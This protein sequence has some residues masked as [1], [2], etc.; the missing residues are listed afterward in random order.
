MV[1]IWLH[2]KIVI[3]HSPLQIIFYFPFQPTKR[4]QVLQTTVALSHCPFLVSE[5]PV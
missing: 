3:S 5:V 2:L 1:A 4:I